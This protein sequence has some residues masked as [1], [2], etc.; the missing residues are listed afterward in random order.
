MDRLIKILSNIRL[1]LFGIL[2]IMLLLV[3]I[4][5]VITGV[6]DAFF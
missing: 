6:Y 2:A 4:S 1:V 5:A 3:V